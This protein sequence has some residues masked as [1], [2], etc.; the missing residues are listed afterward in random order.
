MSK[1]SKPESGADQFTPGPW[2]IIGA[3]FVVKFGDDWACIAEMSNPRSE[4]EKQLHTRAHIHERVEPWHPRFKEAAANASLISA[5]PD[6]YKALDRA[7]L[8]FLQSNILS[9]EDW[10]V[11]NEM[12]AA[13]ARARGE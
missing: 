5:A 3:T 12:R 7:H 6:M 13:L 8:Y 1:P 9:A 2:E 4:S 10:E 11:L